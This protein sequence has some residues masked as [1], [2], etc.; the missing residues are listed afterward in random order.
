MAKVPAKVVVARMPIVPGQ[1]DRVVITVDLGEES[2]PAK[3]I[4][5]D[6]VGED[7]HPLPEGDFFKKLAETF[8]RFGEAS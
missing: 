5:I 4:I 6:V 8:A 3:E 1:T 2:T 7:D